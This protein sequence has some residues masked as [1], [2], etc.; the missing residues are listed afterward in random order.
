MGV[1]L[2]TLGV[3]D[4]PDDVTAFDAALVALDRGMAFALE[5]L[6]DA[7]QAFADEFVAALRHQRDHALEAFNARAI[8]SGITASGETGQFLGGNMPAEEMFDDDAWAKAV[9][10]DLAPA[11]TLVVEEAA[12][13]AGIAVG[14][15][16]VTNPFVVEAS[17]RHIATIDA[18]SGAIRAHVM[19]S[20]EAGL[21][22]G[23]S[24]EHTAER[25][26][27]S[28]PFRDDFTAA[29][30]VAQTELVAARNGGSMAMYE[31]AEGVQVK[32]LA[33]SDDRTRPD[34]QA[35]PPN[36]QVI[37]PADG[38]LFD[39]GGEKAAYPGATNLSVHLRINCRC[40]VSPLR[41]SE[42]SGLTNNTSLSQRNSQE[43]FRERWVEVIS[44]EAAAQL[45]AFDLVLCDSPSQLGL[46]A[47][48]E[49]EMATTPTKPAEFTGEA[50]AST[51]GLLHQV[52]AAGRTFALD[53]PIT[54]AAGDSLVFSIDSLEVS[55]TESNQTSR[56]VKVFDTDDVDEEVEEGDELGSK[57]KKSKAKKKDSYDDD[58]ADDVDDA[59]DVDSDTPAPHK[60]TNKSGMA[61]NLLTLPGLGEL[62]AIKDRADGEMRDDF[63]WSGPVVFEGI[64]TGDG[65]YIADN[66]LDWRDLPLTLMF[67]KENLGA[68]YG[69]TP[70]GHMARMEPRTDGSIW[71]YGY[72]D[73]GEA[74]QEAKR[75]ISEKT[76]RGISVDLSALEYVYDFEEDLFIITKARI[77]GATI[78]PFPAF[79]GA[80]VEL[81]AG[82]EALA[83]AGALRSNLTA[84]FGMPL[85]A[86]ADNSGWTIPAGDDGQ[87]LVASGGRATSVFALKP[88]PA[89]FRCKN[90]TD[91]FRVDADG[92]LSGLIT[93]WDAVHLSFSGAEIHPPRSKTNYDMLHKPGTMICSDGSE[94][95]V[96]RVFGDMDHVSTEKRIPPE[97]VA[98]AYANTGNL[99]AFARFY[100]TEHGIEVAGIMAPGTTEIDAARLRGCDIS[101]DWRPMASLPFGD[102]LECVA[103]LAVNMSGFNLGLAASGAPAKRRPRCKVS[104]NDQGEIAAMT[105]SPTGSPVLSETETLIAE[106]SARLQKLEIREIERRRAEV[107]EKLAVR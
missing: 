97:D 13:N 106:F 24:V 49:P 39:V 14:L 4:Y 63:E 78:T 75:M 9:D 25:I 85:V 22:N 27:E 72:W 96:G 68:H 41:R 11:I 88:D 7:E 19:R 107:K 86:L 12:K 40:A 71:S 20:I 52:V 74:G 76:L 53:E 92:V 17:A 89:V 70:A 94:V 29:R 31:L 101:P 8:G 42:R 79:E 43:L 99:L 37:V 32:W 23:L 87:P 3:L 2:H 104:F 58:A 100:D 59:V 21:R 5:D 6:G 51:P 46:R 18:Y 16:Q 93:T 57:K 90:T 48:K 81:N 61:D 35:N 33:R 34:H 47:G 62:A 102:N 28:G 26:A 50:A 64:A 10:E 67:S 98:A 54:L 30:A 73:S 69:S 82:D 45:G 80:Y 103:M 44:P 15:T 84:R 66:A 56:V 38:E 65:R 36:G 95:E 83:A 105:G 91:P 1:C 77:M 60:S 55:T